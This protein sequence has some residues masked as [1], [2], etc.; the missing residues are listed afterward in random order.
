MRGFQA[1]FFFFLAILGSTQRR[2][3]PPPTL[4]RDKYQASTRSQPRAMH[5]KV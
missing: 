5:A 4:R 3:S 1:L 2:S